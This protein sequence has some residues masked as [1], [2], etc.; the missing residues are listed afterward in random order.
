[1][2]TDFIAPMELQATQP[3]VVAAPARLETMLENE[4]VGQGNPFG[5]PEDSYYA[6][7]FG[8]E[9]EPPLPQWAK[10][11]ISPLR[12]TDDHDRKMKTFQSLLD[13]DL[14]SRDSDPLVSMNLN[15]ARG[16]CL[17]RDL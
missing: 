7:G 15:T 2:F 17:S 1:M 8:W 3:L 9:G 12:T 11:D 6:L 4:G 10:D 5:A 14:S 13:S 16:M